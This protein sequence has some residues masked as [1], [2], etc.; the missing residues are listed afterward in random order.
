MKVLET[1]VFRGPNIYSLKPV[2]RL[3]LDIEELEERPSNTIEGFTDRLIEMI[4][5]LY[6]HRC[7]EGVPGGFISR[8]RSGTWMGHIVEHIALELQCLVGTHVGYGKCR[9]AGKPGLY[10]VIYSYV[11]EKVGL[12]AGQM[13]IQLVEHLVYGKEFN[14]EQQLREL[15]RTL[16]RC[17]YGPSTQAMIDKAKERDIPVLRLNDRNLVQL[18]HG[19]YQKR[20][21]ATVTSFTNL[22]AVDIACDKELTKKLLDDVGIPVPK[23]EVVEDVEAAL[24]AARTLGYPVVV[25]PLDGNHGKGVAINVQD[26][27]TLRRAFEAAYQYSREVIVERYIKGRDHRILVI[28]GEVVA[29]AE[30]V[31]AHVV[32]DGRHTVKELVEIAN[33][34]PRRGEGHE[35]PLTKIVI[36]AESERLLEEQGLTLNSV[37]KEGQ[38]VYLKYTANIS[39][40][41]TAIDRTDEVHYSVVEMAKRAARVI[42]LD[43][44]GI[45]LITTD[46]TRPVEETGGAI[47]EV[48][49]APGF[50]MHVHPT[51]GKPRDV[52]TPVLEMLFPPGTPSRIPI[53][54]VTGT[55]GKTTTVR[56]VAHILKMA[57]K[58]VGLSTTDGIY[59][60]GKKILTG[61]LTGPWSAQMV[62]RDPTVEFAVLETAR[63]GILRAGLGFDRCNIGVITNISEDHLGSGGIETLEDLA[64][65]KSL[66]IEVVDPKGY[67]ILNAE[68]PTVVKLA[69]RSGGQ[70]AYFALNPENETIKKHRAAQ[71]TVITVVD[72]VIKIFQGTYEI[73]VMNVNS[74]PA[75]FN[76]RA[77][78]NVANAITAVLA[79]YLSGVKIDD[80][81]AGLKTFSTNFNSAPGRLN[82][83]TVG[84]FHVLL[85]YAHNIAAYE[86]LCK[87]AANFKVDRKIGV[88]AAPG[89]RR[90]IDI[91]R[92]GQV[93]GKTFS[94][95]IIKEDD[96]R[97]G[98]AIGEVAAKLKAA[99]VSVGMPEEKIEVIVDEP[100][101]VDAALKMGRKD[102]LI[103]IT[104]DNIKRCF[105]QV[106][107]FRDAKQSALV[108]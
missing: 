72:N 84:D 11:E 103:L 12:Q 90:D 107:R 75:T 76:G 23:G 60:D 44:A 94:Y 1:R 93:V 65:V 87:F 38:V 51:E 42:G 19:V 63:G 73:P 79:A 48:N 57:G 98:R 9:S 32:G 85:D 39:T 97:R 104:C 46:I 96:N 28:N 81:R 7:S 54:A 17:A 34:D 64:H 56:M 31:P 58:K 61:D 33:R 68:D 30:R 25:K 35:K 47:C 45:D 55:N 5:T 59:I 80:I 89:D 82:L 40:G 78:V 62:L 16:E 6:E 92:I 26:D 37:P 102:D 77:T 13:A 99:A 101:A 69:E 36:N 86:S 2:I 91:E 71:G 49:A 95:L 20:I 100:A 52:A 3:L 21:Q 22:I 41:G 66:V 108:V 67:A 27:E 29:V 15:S 24:E 70:V 8:L 50:R 14:Y 88:I 4:P 43:V 53:V 18:G 10:N 74:I 105:E 83:E 106:V